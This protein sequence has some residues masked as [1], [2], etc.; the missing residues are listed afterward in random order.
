MNTETI[1]H[2]VRELHRIWNQ[3]DIDAIPSV[4]SKEFIGHWPKGWRTGDSH[5][6][7][8]IRTAIARIRTAFPDWNEEIL[9]LIVSRDRVVSR[10]LSTGTHHG[11]FAGIAPTGRC[12]KFEEISIYRVTD[13]RIIEQWCLSDDL[14]CSNQLT[15]D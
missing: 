6:H 7:A 9:D 2:L 13:D 10:Y 1:L 11:D 14:L 5:G 3:G 4:Y 8:G 15:N 12:V